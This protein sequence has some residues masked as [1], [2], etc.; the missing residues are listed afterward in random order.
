MTTVYEM[1]YKYIYLAFLCLYVSL[2]F[3]LVSVASVQSDEACF[4]L[5]AIFN[6]FSLLTMSHFA[7]RA[8]WFPVGLKHFLLSLTKAE[9]KKDCRRFCMIKLDRQVHVWPGEGNEIRSILFVWL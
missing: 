5:A 1:C 7:I 8:S 2:T 3:C 9:S 6:L 4:Y